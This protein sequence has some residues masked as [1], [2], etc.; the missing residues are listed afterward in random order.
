MPPYLVK[1]LRT[2]EGML[3]VCG[4]KAKQGGINSQVRHKFFVAPRMGR[5]GEWMEML[6]ELLLCLDVRDAGEQLFVSAGSPRAHLEALGD[7]SGGA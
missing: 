4:C 7:S 5:L 3:S 6:L 1:K 2:R